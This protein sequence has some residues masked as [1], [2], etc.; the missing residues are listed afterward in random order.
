[1]KKGRKT[2]SIVIL[3]LSFIMTTIFTGNFQ[4]NNIA[5]AATNQINIYVEKPTNWSS[6]WIWY[7]SDLSTNAWDTTTLAK[8]P[9]DLQEYRTG[10]YKKTLN[11]NEVQ[12]LF[13]DGTWS[14]KLSNSGTDF[15]TTKDIWIK[16]DGS[17]SYT[18]PLTRETTSNSI[19]VHFKST[20]GNTN[21]YYWNTDPGL[22]KNTWPG[23]KMTS[24]GDD[25]YSY[26]LKGV[27]SASLIFNDGSSQ[28]ADLIRS[29]GEWWYKDNQWY[30][31]NP[32]SSTPD[33]KPNPDPTPDPPNPGNRTDFRDES[34]YFV[35][36][37]RFYDGDTSNNVHCWD[38]AKAGNPDSDPAW[39]GDFKG[40][41]EKL[42]Y[43][44]ALGFSAIWIT[45]VVENASGYDYHG[46]HAIN[47]SKVDSRYE[48]EGA[49]Y[50]DLINA[51]HAK[52]LKIVQDIVLNHTGNFGEENL[53][54]LFR[55]NR[56]LKDI[57][58]NLIKVDV[59][60]K[61]PSNY[62][63]LTPAE[64]YQARIAAMKED[65]KD[66][67]YIY[68]HEKSLSWEGYTVQ[69]GQI[70]GD[71]VDLNTENP[72]V[73]KYL[74]DSYNKYIDMGVD[75][76]RIDTV[77]HI[78]RLTL[79]KEFI[80]A[81]KS[82]GGSNFFMFGEVASRYRQVWNNNIPAISTPFY[83]WKETKDYPWA[84]LADRS[85]STLQHWNDNQQASSQPTSNNHLLNGNT[86]HTPDNSIRSGLDVIDFPM[87]WNFNNARDAY[88]VAVDGD[89]WYSDATWNVTYVDSHD[90]A[91]D[92]APEN[93]RFAG[94]QDT[95]AENLNL[96]FTFRGIPTI[97]YGSEIEFMK[98][99]PIDV[100][101]N[102]PLSTTGRA[103]FGDKI[104]GDVTVNDFAQY[105]G[106]TGTM[107]DTL[108]YPLSKHIQRLNLLRRKIPALRK[109]EYSIEGVSG[110][111]A[112]K[113]RYTNA[114]EGVDSFVL[115]SITDGA[116]FS[117]IP[118]GKY[119]DAI[120]GETK[121][122]TNGTL[123][124]SSVGKGNMRVY[125]LDLPSNGAPG[126]VGENGAYLK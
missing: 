88:N 58:E 25:W 114:S 113:K 57:A 29:Y 7:D 2:I 30:T 54:P 124:T 4:V 27:N 17:L 35:M 94:A 39:R 102:A 19:K 90:Y 69:T 65:M 96:M 20:W 59:D 100:G 115:I 14:N 123:T 80:P 111:M 120:T 71:C 95:W 46:Y 85:N 11:S 109:G 73:S 107:K 41:I 5:F 82:R 16:K 84:T 37:S 91:P 1:M 21:L 70:A 60:G 83:T 28:T 97:Y 45:P 63:S 43:I 104:Q 33:P 121:N 50:Q 26:E 72:E 55:K 24:E 62:N 108:N 6:I 38:D 75:A 49:S 112:F 23:D 34:I 76:F 10:W 40:L 53:F 89:K 3:I 74:I 78:S 117:N 9:G 44:K 106:A 103:Y 12:F 42:D 81:F 79:N 32:E 22:L 77:K 36:T 13:N 122:I 98:G 18:D 105:S 126:K 86:Y 8:S 15:K 61:L 66:T 31:S 68:H 119:V 64:Q 118:N 99:A 48:S 116:T 125:V 93:Q 56:T 87:H 52:G 67:K 51:A 110:N 92:G 47:F 101:P